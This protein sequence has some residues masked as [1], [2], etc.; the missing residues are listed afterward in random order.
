M[1]SHSL[2]MRAAGP[3]NYQWTAPDQSVIHEEGWQR[4]LICSVLPEANADAR[5]LFS[6]ST[7]RHTQTVWMTIG[8]GIGGWKGEERKWASW[9][10]CW[11]L[12][13]LHMNG[14]SSDISINKCVFSILKSNIWTSLMNLIF[15][16]AK[17]VSKQ[18]H[19]SSSLVSSRVV[20]Y[21]AKY[22]S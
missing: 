14:I 7:D 4:P 8:E 16:L 10:E 15:E 2:D 21:G 9:Q 1:S 5:R 20:L 19:H 6:S 12:L 22:D 3:N 17:Q 18:I 11:L 13:W